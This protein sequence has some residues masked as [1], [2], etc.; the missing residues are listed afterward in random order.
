[1]TVNQSKQESVWDY[2]RPATLELSDASLLIKHQGHIIAKSAM[3]YR[4]LETSHPP[5]YYIPESDIVCDLKAS[6]GNTSCE[7]KGVA[8]YWDV[9]LGQLIIKRAAWSY[10]SPTEAFIAIKD[11]YAFYASA[12]DECFVNGTKVDAQAGDFY[13]G[14]ITP[15]I[16]GPFKGPA[17]T[18][19]W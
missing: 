18:R 9:L 16:V 15:N 4:V 10:Q 11:H 3:S 14:W 13:G 12:F 17:G 1:M 2:P 5:T 7:W 19:H 8:S 6:L